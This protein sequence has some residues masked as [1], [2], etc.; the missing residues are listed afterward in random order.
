MTPSG[1]ATT[2]PIGD[3]LPT[4]KVITLG[5]AGVGKLRRTVGVFSLPGIRMVS[6]KTSLINRYVKDEFAITT[7][8]TT[9]F[10]HLQKEVILGERTTVK[11]LLYDTAGQER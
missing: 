5:E 1:S 8:S 7:E 11:L 2:L 4:F 6:G 9:G 10:A 3:A